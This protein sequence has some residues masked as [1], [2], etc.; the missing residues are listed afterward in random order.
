MGPKDAER[1]A[2]NVEPF[3]SHIM[4]KPVFDQVILEPLCSASETSYSLE[5]LDVETSVYSDLTSLQFFSHLTAVSGCDRE[6]NAH[7]YSAASLKYHVP[8]T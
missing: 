2:N 5:I 3:L 6:L 4:R 7:F 8:D 1:M